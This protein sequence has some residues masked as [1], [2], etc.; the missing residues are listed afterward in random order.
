MFKIIIKRIGARENDKFFLRLLF[1]ED[2]KTSEIDI[3][4]QVRF[5]KYIFHKCYRFFAIFQYYFPRT[6]ENCRGILWNSALWSMRSGWNFNSFQ[7]T[8]YNADVRETRKR[9]DNVRSIIIIIPLCETVVVHSCYV[10]S[11]GAD[12]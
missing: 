12:E 2:S 1:S 7:R 6:W 3:V 8:Q 4:K 9:S 10:N 5:I 11:R